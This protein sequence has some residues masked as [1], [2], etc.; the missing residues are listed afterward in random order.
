MAIGPS[1]VEHLA[2]AS[3]TLNQETG[4]K[5][6]LTS[7][8]K[9]MQ[10]PASQT[11][12]ASS[13]EDDIHSLVCVES[14]D[15]RSEKINEHHRSKSGKRRSDFSRGRISLT[16]LSKNSQDALA[17]NGND[18]YKQIPEDLPPAK[19]LCLLSR[20]ALRHTLDVLEDEFEDLPGFGTFKAE[21]LDYVGDT[22]DKMDSDGSFEEASVGPRL[23]PN[24]LNDQMSLTISQLTGSIERMRKENEDWDKLISKLK[25][26]TDNAKELLNHMEVEYNDIP[27][28]VKEMS[29]TFLPSTAHTPDLAALS[30]SV[31]QDVKT[32]SLLMD[33]YCQSI[34]MLNMA[35]SAAHKH[36]DHVASVLK[37]ENGC[38][39][40]LKE[41]I[42]KYLSA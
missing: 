12:S 27:K 5:E 39:H 41:V 4:V 28:E 32:I 25:T 29:K 10:S 15:S 22:I 3:D 26:Q 20:L 8:G 19:R 21:A 9:N 35:S 1:I 31:A 14:M 23:A 6:A 40:D 24:P 33:Q 17:S 7:C 30:Q 16:Q 18:L 36:M 38:N 34:D 11:W 42:L 37:H 2:T 13:V